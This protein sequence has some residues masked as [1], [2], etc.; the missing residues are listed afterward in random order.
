MSVLPPALSSDRCMN[1][2][3]TNKETRSE[4]QDMHRV[5]PEATAG[6]SQASMEADPDDKRLK[7]MHLAKSTTKVPIFPNVYTDLD[8]TIAVGYAY[9]RVELDMEAGEFG[10]LRIRWFPTASDPSC[11]ELAEAALTRHREALVRHAHRQRW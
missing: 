11:L 5:K 7:I 9:P 6:A 3:S 2:E 4:L 8:K 1:A 10:I